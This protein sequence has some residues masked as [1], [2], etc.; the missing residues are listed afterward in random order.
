[1]I[2]ECGI[3]KPFMDLPEAL[4]EEMLFSYEQS[5]IKLAKSFDKILSNKECIRDA[6]KRFN[7]RP[8]SMVIGFRTYPTAC[9]IDGAYAI[10]RLLAT[11]IAGVAAVAV[12]GLTPPTEARHWQQPHHLCRVFTVNHHDA[13]SLILRALMLSM[14]FELAT[15]APHDVVLLDGSLTTPLIHLNQAMGR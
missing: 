11:N 1:M 7:L 10:E 14:E 2:E 4:V 8:D 5:S 9:G 13:I 12:E 3:D 6:L 15:N